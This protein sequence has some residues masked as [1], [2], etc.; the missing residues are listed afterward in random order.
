VERWGYR[1]RIVI[2]S[3][4]LKPHGHHASKTDNIR[5][6]PS[7]RKLTMGCDT[8]FCIKKNLKSK[9]SG[10]CMPKSLFQQMEIRTVHVKSNK[11]G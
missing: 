8:M 1:E 10:K 7:T 2:S 9:S 3:S 4:N 5:M 11:T 6:P